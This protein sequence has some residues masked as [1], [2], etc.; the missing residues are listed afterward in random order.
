MGQASLT[1]GGRLCSRT[2]RK[3][4]LLRRSWVPRTTRSWAA[5][6]P[7]ERG[8]ITSKSRVR[9]REESEEQGSG[10]MRRPIESGT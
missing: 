5:N 3:A 9:T 1:R 6:S 2:E 10:Y 7:Q 8:T 4:C